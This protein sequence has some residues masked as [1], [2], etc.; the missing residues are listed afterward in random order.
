MFKMVILYIFYN[1]DKKRDRKA[2]HGHIFS[3]KGQIV[4]V[5]GFAGQ[6]VCGISAIVAKTATDNS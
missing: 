3:V 5:L 6:V 4:N 2:R 1:N